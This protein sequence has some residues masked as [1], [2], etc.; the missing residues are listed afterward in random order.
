MIAAVF[1]NFKG[2]MFSIMSYLIIKCIPM[3]NMLV[4]RNVVS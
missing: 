4:L 3:V 2:N 1:C